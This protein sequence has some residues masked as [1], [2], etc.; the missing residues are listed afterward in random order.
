MNDCNERIV[1][2]GLKVIRSSFDNDPGGDDCS[3][4]RSINTAD[5]PQ[6]SP[7]KPPLRQHDGIERLLP[8]AGAV[9]GAGRPLAPGCPRC[10]RKAEHENL[11]RHAKGTPQV[12]TTTRA[13]TDGHGSLSPVR[14]VEIPKSSGGIRPLFIPTVADRIAQTV[15][16]QVLEPHLELVF[17]HVSYGYTPGKTAHRAVEMCRQRCWRTNSVHGLDIKWFFDAIDIDLL[18]RAV[19]AHTSERWVLLYLYRWLQAPDLLPD[20]TLQPR[21]RGTP[22]GGIASPLLNNLFLHYAF[23]GWMRRSNPA[24]AFERYADN[25]ILHCRITN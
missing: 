9:H 21:E 12:A 17:D 3:G 4:G 8:G 1:R 16:K 20:G 13:N 5:Q 11:P 25:T 18:M 2:H 23:D 14:S 7:L 15:V 24:I 19:M 10:Q 6:P 22:E